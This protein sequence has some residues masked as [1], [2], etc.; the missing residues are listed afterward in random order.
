MAGPE[1]G[2]AWA[3]HRSVGRTRSPYSHAAADGEP[4]NTPPEATLLRFAWMGRLS[5]R[6][7]QDPTLSF[8]RQLSNSQLALPENA[9]IVARFYDVESGRMDLDARGR[10]HAH[11][12][13]D[14]PIP[15]DGGIADLLD[16]AERPD[17][18]FDYVICEGIERTARHMYHGVSI[19]HRLQRAGVRL[20]AADEP[21]QLTSP[22]GRKP[23]MAT[24]LLTRRVK[25]SISEFY[26]VD[27]LEKS[28]DG[29]AI[30][31]E[32]GYNVGKP[33][34]GYRAKHVPHPVPAKRAK[35]VKKTYLEPDPI[36]A[37]TVRTIFA[38]RV[39]QRLGYQ[40]IAD[41]LNQD[42]A[43]Y[44][45]PTPV[46]PSRSV[47]H[48]TYSNVRDV[49]TFSAPIGRRLSRLGGGV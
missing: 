12:Q 27:L 34:Y 18:R 1:Q 10:G 35:G 43:T 23:K 2:R 22:T 33:C 11:E 19:E 8:P 16:E 46:D 47:G 13:F 3:G 9:V 6:D 28:W 14:I 29:F 26:V 48:W 21:F 30:H 40:A 37:P 49:L 45:P 7:M 5:T 42:L 25:Q 31:A 17:R 36:Q 44:R 39:G 20:L 38:W 41:R 4:L 15:R 32:Q 24:Q